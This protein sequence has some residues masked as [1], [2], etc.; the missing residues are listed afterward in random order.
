MTRADRSA[1]AVQL[2]GWLLA[3]ETRGRALDQVLADLGARL[4]A[5]GVP[6]S[7]M[8]TSVTNK[9]PEL[10][11]RV[12]LWHAE[13]GTEV[14]DVTRDLLVSPTYLDSPVARVRAG[15][16][17]IRCHLTGPGADLS[18]DICRELAAEG[19]TDYAVYPLL[20]GAG[21]R[22]YFSF[23]TDAS[24]GFSAADLALL[25]AL[26]PALSVRVEIE[27]ANYALAS[28]LEVYL[29]RNAAA[30]VLAGSFLR[31]T[32]QLIHAAIWFCDMRGFTALADRSPASEVVMALDRF[33]EAVAGPIGTHG[34]EVLKF[35]GDAVLA[36]FPVIADGVG[37]ACGRA[38]AAANAAVHGVARLNQTGAM[39]P[40]DLGIG[41]HVGEV[42]YGNIGARDRLDFTVIGAVVNEVCRVESLCRTLA[43]PILMTAAFAAACEGARV[44]SRG[45]HELKGVAAPQEIYAPTELVFDA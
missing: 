21:E 4:I 3:A 14:R 6:V 10:F 24:E 12:V 45:I 7:R 23:A 18:F 44:R 19:L 22:T 35:I 26:L 28:L 16:P 39:P 2:T 37:A 8:R 41:L 1:V 43:S 33:F 15:E 40:M 17:S 25:E 30:R 29:G 32:G 42:M 9:H 20:F 5:A 13:R 27:S 34:G 36:I 31:G 38:L 11:V